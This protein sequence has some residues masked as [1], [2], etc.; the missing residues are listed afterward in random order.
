MVRSSETSV[1][2]PKLT[3]SCR[4]RLLSALS[5]PWRLLMSCWDRMATA[6]LVQLGGRHLNRLLWEFLQP[7]WVSASPFTVM[8]P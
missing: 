2:Y 3:A 7:F 4:R 1:N 8:S 6:V 5:R